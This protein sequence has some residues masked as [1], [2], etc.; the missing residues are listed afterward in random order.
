VIFATVLASPWL[1]RLGEALF[2][3]AARSFAGHV[4]TISAAQG[5][6]QDRRPSEEAGDH[7]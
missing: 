3:P 7:V 4:T 6:M 5:P 2:D 1:S